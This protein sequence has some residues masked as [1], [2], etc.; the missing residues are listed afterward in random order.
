MAKGELTRFWNKVSVGGGRECWVWVGGKD[1]SG[2]GSFRSKFGVVRASRFSFALAYG[3]WPEVARHTC[4]NP[5][6]VNPAHLIAGTHQD[7]VADRVQRGR[8][9][10][11]STNGRSVLTDFEVSTLRTDGAT[12]TNELA[13]TLGVNATTI[14]DVRKQKS[15]KSGGYF[16]DGR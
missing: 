11:G 13:A 10:A 14:C 5:A 1:S 9:A 15:W 2:Y 8:S 4:D 12:S 6:C 7:N 3:Y 16:R